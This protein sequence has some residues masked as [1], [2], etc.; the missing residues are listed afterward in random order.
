MERSLV[1]CLLMSA[2]GFAQSPKQAEPVRPD[3]K[4][5]PAKPVPNPADS[6]LAGTLWKLAKITY[7][8]GKVHNPD[9][10]EK[11]TFEFLPGGR[12]N[13]RIDCNRGS[14]TWA[15][16]APGRISFGPISSTI[17]VCP[18]G[19]LDRLV[20][21]DLPDFNGYEIKEGRLF[22]SLKDGSGVYKLERDGGKSTRKTFEVP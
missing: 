1:F 10:P 13:A 2:A 21:R 7:K 22:L 19:S 4:P 14:G 15:S 12:L 16:S 3:P 18:P 5:E 6:E 20:V 9:K 11:Y 17:M 8:D